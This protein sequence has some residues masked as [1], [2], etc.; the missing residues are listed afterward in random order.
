MNPWFIQIEDKET[1]NRYTIY[2]NGLV[3]GPER[4]DKMFIL[5]KSAM[6]ELKQIIADNIYAY[7]TLTYH[8]AKPSPIVLRINDT[9]RKHRNI[10]I[11]GAR[12]LPRILSIMLNESN[13]V[14]V[15]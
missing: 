11:V 8:K 14:K 3:Y 15:F 4:N 13:Y 7:K 10:K 5:S 2:N 12:E 1:K 6:E 9:S